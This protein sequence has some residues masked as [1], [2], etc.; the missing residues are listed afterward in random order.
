MTRKN[1]KLLV[2]TAAVG[3]VALTGTATAAVTFDPAT[4]TGFVGK[5]DVQVPFGWNDAKLQQY[6]SGVSFEYESKSDDQYA[7]TCEWETGNKKI[8]HHIQKKRANVGSSVAYDVTKID[9]KNPNGKVTG[10]SL[11]GINDDS[12]VESSSGSVPVEGDS[13]PETGNEA[14]T[15]NAVD[16]KITNVELLSSTATESLTAL[17]AGLGL[18][19][20]IWPPPPAI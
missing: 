3:A 19:A 10:F 12:V 4:G 15:D 17:H 13:C 20:V 16:K 8:V 1:L 6:A 5:G 7:V 18:S 9:R 14:G 11:T 2:A